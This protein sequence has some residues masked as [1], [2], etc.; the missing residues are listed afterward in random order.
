MKKNIGSID[1]WIRVI[2][3]LVIGALGIVFNSWWGLL[4]IVF[5]ATAGIG[6]CPLYLPFG[7]ST[8]KKA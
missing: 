3:G 5:L 8:R 6:T 2:A 1:R 4:G 7:I